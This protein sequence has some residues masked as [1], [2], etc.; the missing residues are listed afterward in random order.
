ML[1]SGHLLCK[2]RDHLG[3]VDGAGRL[4]HQVVGLGVCDGAADVH[5]GGLEVGG[6]DDAVL[7]NIDDSKSFLEFLNL[8]LAE[9]REDVRSRLLCL[10]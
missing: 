9:E 10:L 8:F 5:E 4:A 2:Q 6:G 7:V 3:E 1:T